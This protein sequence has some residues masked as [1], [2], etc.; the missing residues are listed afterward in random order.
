M[1]R[2]VLV[3]GASGHGKVVADI[4]RAAGL[5]LAGFVDDDPGR[6]EVGLWGLPV[7][8]WAECLALPAGPGRPA[9]ALGIG[10]N[11]ARERVLERIVAG[12]F[13]VLTVVHPRA[14]VSPRARLGTGT[15]VMAL[16]AVNPDADVGAGV[17]L[18]T[19]CVV[20]H[21][22]RIGDFAHLSPNSALGGGVEIGARSHLGLGAVVLPLVKV[23]ADVRVGAGA[24]VTGDAPPGVTLVG[25]PARPVPLRGP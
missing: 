6:R 5:E 25:V 8:G 17:I 16:V 13:E 10:D 1:N 15:V 24:A 9:I 22:C 2:P 11:R 21:D 19:G 4:V 20:E 23:G 18:N 12:G 14:A 3:F 7:R